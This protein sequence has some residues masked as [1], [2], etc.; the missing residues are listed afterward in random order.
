MNKVHMTR[1]LAAR[2]ARSSPASRAQSIR[3]YGEKSCALALLPCYQGIRMHVQRT[4]LARRALAREA[5]SVSACCASYSALLGSL[6]G[7]RFGA[8]LA[9]CGGTHSPPIRPLALRS[10]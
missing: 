10:A 7:P 8:E 5:A 4:H 3:D 1:T 6:V 9:V 2:A